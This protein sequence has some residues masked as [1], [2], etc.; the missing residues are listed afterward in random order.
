MGESIST[1]QHSPRKACRTNLPLL[2]FG[3][4]RWPC[5][6][7]RWAL[8][9]AFQRRRTKR[10]WHWTIAQSC[11]SLTVSARLRYHVSNSV[12][13]VHRAGSLRKDIR[14]PGKLFS[15]AEPFPFEK[16]KNIN[17]VYSSCLKHANEMVLGD[18]RQAHQRMQSLH[19][20]SSFINHST[21]ACCSS[22]QTPSSLSNGDW[23]FGPR[24]GRSNRPRDKIRASA[25]LRARH[26]RWSAWS[27]IYHFNH[28]SA[29]RSKSKLWRSKA[30]GLDLRR[31]PLA[32]CHGCSSTW[33]GPGHLMVSGDFELWAWAAWERLCG[34]QE[35][36]KQSC[37]V[38]IR[39]G[40]RS[41]RK[42][43]WAR[44]FSAHTRTH[45]RTPTHIHMDDVINLSLLWHT[46]THTHTPFS[47]ISTIFTLHS[48]NF[49]WYL[50]VIWCTLLTDFWY[51]PMN[52]HSFVCTMYSH[53][54][55]RNTQHWTCISFLLSCHKRKS[56]A[57]DEFPWYI[58]SIE[59]LLVW[60]W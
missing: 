43:R 58:S 49:R 52:N 29:E 9:L 8:N 2:A 56:H 38:A 24:D 40:S 53:V 46:H 26:R 23:L 11:R 32:A 60:A 12:V 3:C 47:S 34:G 7:F 39:A 41:F 51:L 31:S 54:M 17:L 5:R 21:I 36:W 35:R 59:Q 55:R 25:S 30:L 57:G 6:R 14:Y 16:G 37:F 19:F 4:R 18:P 20:P 28:D 44:F 13:C 45:A 48:W 1:I 50:L 10:K 33:L 22:A 15:K 42:V 27:N